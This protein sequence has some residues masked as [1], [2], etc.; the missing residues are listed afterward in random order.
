MSGTVG[1][2]HCPE[3][4]IYLSKVQLSADNHRKMQS[5][6]YL[7]HDW[8]E[9]EFF[10]EFTEGETHAAYV[11]RWKRFIFSLAVRKRQAYNAAIGVEGST[12][13]RSMIVFILE[14]LAPVC[15]DSVH[16]RSSSW[17][18]RLLQKI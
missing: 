11:S 1:T 2:R 13:T 15:D 8:C 4:L 3:C 14:K 6:L 10:R 18:D 5:N 12:E 17:Q 9:Q 16:W 7:Y